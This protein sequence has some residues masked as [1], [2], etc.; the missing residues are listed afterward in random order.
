MRFATWESNALQSQLLMPMTKVSELRS[1]TERPVSMWVRCGEWAAKLMRSKTYLWE[2]IFGVSR[3]ARS[4][5][6]L[7]PVYCS[8]Y[9]RILKPTSRFR[10]LFLMNFFSAVYGFS[11]G[12]FLGEV[13]TNVHLWS[14]GF[15]GDVHDADQVKP[16]EISGKAFK[17]IFWRRIVGVQAGPVSNAGHIRERRTRVFSINHPPQGASSAE[18]KNRRDSKSQDGNESLEL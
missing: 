4:L 8:S 17:L 15:E 1:T 7:W 11:G 12:V 13:E 10:A 18:S 16:A 2:Y 14:E 9:R 5:C 6:L 3:G